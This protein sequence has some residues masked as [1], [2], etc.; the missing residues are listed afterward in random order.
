MAQRWS[1]EIEEEELSSNVRFEKEVK[2]NRDFFEPI[3]NNQVR[4]IT[5]RRNKHVGCYLKKRRRNHVVTKTLACWQLCDS[6]FMVYKF[7]T[8]LNIQSNFID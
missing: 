3:K 7:V 8:R 2:T 6:E 4:K 1:R 5:Y